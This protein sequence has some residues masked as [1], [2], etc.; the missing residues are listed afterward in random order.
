M[1]ESSGVQQKICLQV[2]QSALFLAIRR[3]WDRSLSGSAMTAYGA[4]ELVASG[5]LLQ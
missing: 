1:F 3:S 5:Y 2:S 4:L